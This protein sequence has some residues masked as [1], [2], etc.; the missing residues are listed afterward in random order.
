VPG[1]R[2]YAPLERYSLSLDQINIL[3]GPN[4]CGKSTIISAFRAVDSALRA[5]KSR[6]PG[7]VYFDDSSEIG[8]GIPE[9][10][11]PI[12]LENIHT[13]YN[14]SASTITFSLSNRNKLRLIFSAEGGCVLI[15]VVEGEI[16]QSAAA[17]KRHFPISMTVVPVLGPVEHNEI[18]REKATVTDGLSTHRASRHFRN[19]WYYFPE[20]FKEFSELVRTTWP[21]ME[22]E[23]PE[24]DVSSGTLRM[25]CREDRLIRELYWVGFGFQIWC[26]L[27]THLSRS[28]RSSLVVV[29]EPETYL[30]PDVQR[31]LLG[32]VRDVGADVLLATHSSEIM[33][34]ADPSEIVFVDRRRRAGDRLKDVVGVQK[35]LDAVGSA[36]NITLTA[37]ARSRRVLFVEGEDDF[38]LLRRFA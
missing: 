18:R 26:Q 21:G 38:R 3:V 17:F 16:I 22:V 2:N 36:Q 13:N 23:A 8:Y 28:K 11:L 10:S 32:I 33:S 34:E 31:Q 5:T 14:T 27:L 6:P 24:L 12:A 4:N 30:H 7:R 15:P 25:F 37:L 29:D 1:C 35:A 20:F 9:G 19:Y